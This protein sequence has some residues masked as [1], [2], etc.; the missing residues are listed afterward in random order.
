MISR[1]CLMSLY[2][3]KTFIIP[4]TIRKVAETLLPIMPPTREKAPNREETAAA[5]EATTI[6]VITT[7]LFVNQY[8]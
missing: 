8:A 7:M 6:E 3:M 2:R 1:N 4:S 5:V